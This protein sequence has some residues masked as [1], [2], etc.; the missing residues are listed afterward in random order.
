VSDEWL[1]PTLLNAAFDAGDADKA[2]ELIDVII[3]EGRARWKFDSIQ[4]DLEDSARQVA[5]A[6]QSERLQAVVRRLRTV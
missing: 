6:A 4:N 5:D 1:R 2:E 3:G